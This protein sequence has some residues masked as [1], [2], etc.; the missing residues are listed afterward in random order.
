MIAYDT[1]SIDFN[2]LFDLTNTDGGMNGTGGGFGGGGGGGT[3]IPPTP[4][5]NDIRLTFTNL[6]QYK[7]QMTFNV[8]GQIYQ[9]TN[10]AVIDSNTINDILIIKPIVNDEYTLKN[11]FELRK[12]LITK[13]I[14][15]NDWVVD[16]NNFGID[17]ASSLYGYGNSGLGNLPI[18]RWVEKIE[19]T[20]ISGIVLNNYNSN[21][22]LQGTQEYE[23]PINI[24]LGFDIV[25][26]IVIKT[27]A[28]KIQSVFLVT[29][30]NNSKLNDELQVI[31]NS[32]DLSVPKTLKI[33]ESIDISNTNNSSEDLSISIKGL[34]SFQL[35]NI[36]WQYANK[37]DSNSIFDVNDFKILSSDN[38][39]T[40]FSNE[41]NANIILLI[42]VQPDTSKYASLT[43]DK[44][45]IDVSI[46]ES[47]FDS[48][49]AS[50]LI[51]I[52]Y[53]LVATDLVKIITPYREF[54]QS[55]SVRETLSLDLKRDFLNNAGSFK[56]LFT[57][58]STLYGDGIT[59][60]L[61][62]NISKI[63]DIPIIDK[64]DYPKNIVIPSYSFGN[65]A[66]KIEYESN[67]ATK[68][69]VYHTKED[70]NYLLANGAAK[71]S[72]N[73]TYNNLKAFVNNGILDLLLVPYNNNVK[74]E[75]ERIS[76]S[77]NDPGFYVSTQNLKDELFNAIVSQLKLNLTKPKYLNHLASFDK[78]DKQI[79]ISNWDVDNSTFTKFKIDELG[80][81][82]PDGEI[83]KSVVIKLYEPLPTTI[84]KNDALWISE[85][86][87]LPILQSVVLSGVASDICIPLRAPNFNADIDF[88][89]G[90]ST[91][92]ETY[93]NLIL[94][95]STSS[96][97]LVDKYLV[98]NFIDVKGI[99]IEFESGSSPAFSNFVKYSSAVE[100]LANF[101]YKKELTEFYDWQ[102]ITLSSGSTTS[103][104]ALNLDI[105]TITEKKNN[106]I[107]GF[108]NWETFLTQSVFTGSFVD[109][110]SLT[111]YSDYLNLATQYDKT[112]NNALKNNI[113]LH[114]VEDTENLDFTLF[115]DMVGNYF[116]IIWAYIKGMTDQKKITE[117]NIDGIEDKFLY[118]YLESFGWNAKNLSS[119]KQLWNYTFGFNN[120]GALP[121]YDI[122]HLG[123]NT[124]R[125]TPEQATHQIWRRI[126][127]NLPYLLK[128]KGSHRGIKALLTCYG[129]PASNISIIEFGGP[130]IDTIEDAPKFIYESLTHNLVFDNISAS[131][132]IPFT[133]T[134]KPQ[135]IEFKFKPNSFEEYT[136]ITGSGDF[137][138]GIVGDS[139]PSIIGSKYGYIKVNGSSVGSSYPFYDGNY[140]SILINKSGSSVNVYAKTNDKDRI[141]HSGEW[142]KNITGSNYE[143]TTTLKFTGFKGHLEEIRLWETNLSE[144]VFN[145]HV[146]MPEAI[147]GNNLYSST[148][149][150]LLRLDFERPQDLSSNRTIN[151]IAPS[152]DYVAAVSASGFVSASS[153]PYNYEVLE[154]DVA[155]TI[156]NSGASRYYTNKVRLESQEL[157]NN[158]SPIKRATKKA[159]ETSTKDSNR[160]GLFFSPNKDLDLDIAKSL[161]GQSFDDFIGDPQYE[162]NTLNY[163]GLDNL[164][165]YYFERVGE[166]NL[167]EFIRLIKFYDK[168]LF[169]NLKEMM[170]ARAVVTTGLLIAPHLLERNRIKINR[171]KATAESLEGIVTE[172]QITELT[173]T[174]DYKEANLNLTASVENISGVNQTINGTLIASD[175]YN[176]SAQ[177]DSFTTIINTDLANVADGSYITY[178][179][180]IDFRL[181][182][183]TI[184]TELELLNAGQIIGMDDA[185]INYGYGTYFNNGYGKYFY[186]ENGSFKSKAVRG[187][188]V[189]KQT[190]TIT[191]VTTYYAIDATNI[192]L[193]VNGGY[194]LYNDLNG[195]EVTLT[196]DNN[197]VFN[198]YA[199]EILYN[200]LI[201]C[202][203]EHVVGS[204]ANITTSSYSQ[205]LIIQDS[206][207]ILNSASLYN[208]SKLSNISLVNGYL[209]SHHIY[210]GDKHTGIENLF[211]RG[212]KQTS[213][214]ANGVTSSYTTIDG[215]SPVEIFT[216]NPT[217]LRVT[218]Q[219]RSNNEPILEVD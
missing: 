57:P 115:L 170:P 203:L 39:A 81:Q 124:A 187:F 138:I 174:F 107:V 146:I 201:G 70:D 121:A 12:K 33:G 131:L 46:A 162:Y 4:P 91:G 47:I 148:Q 192:P 173:S 167:Y 2:P 210:K 6:S 178:E 155:L 218:S 150:L 199:R 30:Y 212:C 214:I 78:D 76:I 111:L 118:Q 52:S 135:S 116:D 114:I 144:S 27:P 166:R 41:F 130:N 202:T 35:S 80:N 209:P 160:V 172:T 215:K 64:I 197:I 73:S 50:K 191:N 175:T 129:I 36:R 74:G 151:N 158:L 189:T 181:K 65:V 208:D 45:I 188:L 23:L 108:D 119:N 213:Y 15:T 105:D 77:F 195:N 117:S 140:H 137:K 198:F 142:T 21:N 10:S 82:V 8:Q 200:G 156:P 11:Y 25:N 99:N 102:L 37:F 100:R 219:G 154:R 176:F 152:L 163:P 109:Q 61:I 104:I 153:Y 110:G 145:N 43:L 204:D 71:T 14:I 28:I 183:S 113:P 44:T 149:D 56:L 179:G 98:D 128:H 123:E 94:S 159:F 51:D 55:P 171:P 18:G 26:N 132:D 161:G 157:V 67:L 88:I 79:V 168:S 68:V 147:N 89:G 106:L 3:Y 185:Y 22:E 66:F 101:R 62:V 24:D 31:I 182:D 13:K 184:T 169:V 58:Y 54:T 125:I 7:N 40:L 216:T 19:T 143:N 90:Q 112:N 141:I 93:D 92:F 87:A 29:N 97:Q 186:E 9:E 193:P 122:T 205:K 217:T 72:Y 206:A 196:I 120:D 211:Y 1:T 194:V 48:P 60:T 134:T 139:A 85:L 69:L 84:N 53:T 207:Q 164:R 133:G 177:A 86:S 180:E 16:Y 59:Q 32:K 126:A 75:I 34:S 38:I 127:N 96:Q 63:L 83:N 49:T 20:Q 190:T 103:S 95:G 42:E 136:F 5:G 165:N 17:P